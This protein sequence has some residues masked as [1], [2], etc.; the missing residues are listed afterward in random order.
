MK[1]LTTA[2]IYGDTRV[3]EDLNYYFPKKFEDIGI[4]GVKCEYDGGVRVDFSNKPMTDKLLSALTA[5]DEDPYDDIL[6]EHHADVDGEDTYAEFKKSFVD[7]TTVGF[8]GD[9]VGDAEVQIN[10]NNAD[11]WVEEL[12]DS[13]AD[14]LHYLISDMMEDMDSEFEKDMYEDSSEEE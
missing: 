14:T 3:E 2:S 7:A 12:K 13:I 9:F 6:K 11:S 4:E 10:V 8:H 5:K 1:R